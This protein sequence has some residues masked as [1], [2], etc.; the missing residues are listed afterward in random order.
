MR[1]A[2]KAL[3][4]YNSAAASETSKIKA[5]TLKLQA[6]VKTHEI[7]FSAG[8]L[9]ISFT[10]RDIEFEPGEAGK[11]SESFRSKSYRHSQNEALHINSIRSEMNLNS[12]SLC[13][14]EGPKKSETPQYLRNRAI[15]AYEA[16]S[17]DSEYLP[18]RALGSV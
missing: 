8:R 16:L 7:G 10:S 9:G 4:F 5:E 18:G 11:S 6:R 14:L 15:S 2:P 17:S 13:E 1:I 3:E 12:L